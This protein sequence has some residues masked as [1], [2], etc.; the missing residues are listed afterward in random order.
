MVMGIIEMENKAD[1]IST[2]CVVHSAEKGPR[3]FQACS[4]LVVELD[5]PNWEG[6]WRPELIQALLFPL[7]S[8]SPNLSLP[9]VMKVS[10]E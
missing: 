9:R 2:S 4:L 8:S 5:Q 10:K 1:V 3:F 7:L 6:H